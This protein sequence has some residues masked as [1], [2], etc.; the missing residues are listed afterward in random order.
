MSKIIAIANQKGGVGKTTTAVNLSSC[1]AEL[2]VRVLAVDIDPQGNMTS[3]LGVKDKTSESIYDVI[4]N[5]A[6]ARDVIV[7]T[8]VENLDIIPSEINLSGA[9][10]EL[11]NV[12]AREQVLKRALS[13]IK[14]EYDY[15]TIDCPP[16]LGLLTL[17]ALT[18]AATLLVPIQC[19]YYALEGL[20]QLMNT[21]SLVRK[22]LNPAIAVEGVVMTMYD[23]RTNLSAQVVN[24]VKKLFKN[25]VYE[26]IIPRSVKLG[27]APSFGLPINLYDPKCAGAKAYTD[28]AKELIEKDGNN[29]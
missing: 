14:N 13:E 3:G 10:V 29:K 11:V 17:N 21:V 19:E 7:G 22:H 27:E 1:L 25:K 5:G 8:A 6:S 2:G 24:E 20:V 16:S 26:T 18:A 23:V 9:E 15:I 12:M 28:L 4:I